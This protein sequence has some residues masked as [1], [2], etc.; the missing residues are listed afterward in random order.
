MQ[1][2][3]CRTV[4]FRISQT[5]AAMPD[6]PPPLQE[7]GYRILFECFRGIP[8]NGGTGDCFRK[9]RD[10]GP[11]RNPQIGK[12]GKTWLEDWTIQS[13]FSKTGYFLTKAEG[14]FP[15]FFCYSRSAFALLCL[16][17]GFRGSELIGR[18]ETSLLLFGGSPSFAAK[19]G[20]ERR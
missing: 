16:F 10:G 7:R 8:V 5:I 6:P 17:P 14:V 4:F 13:A 1:K 20:K 12:R 19:D 15:C 3:P 18:E 9:S 11:L 2:C